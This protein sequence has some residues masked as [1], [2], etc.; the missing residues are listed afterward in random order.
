MASC[1]RLPY[2]IERLLGAG[3]RVIRTDEE[4]MIAKSVCRVL[5]LSIEK[6]DE[7]AHEDEKT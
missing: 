7:H 5:G 4:L 3:V 1:F 6:E 2:L